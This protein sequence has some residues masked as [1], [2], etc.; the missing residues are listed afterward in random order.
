[1][2]DEY[3]YSVLDAD[4][5]FGFDGAPLVDALHE[6]KDFEAQYSAK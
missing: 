6:A 5:I 3:Y 1:M 2:P 4:K